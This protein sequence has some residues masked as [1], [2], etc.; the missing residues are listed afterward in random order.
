[1][2]IVLH[3]TRVA[4]LCCNPSFSVQVHKDPVWMVNCFVQPTSR[5]RSVDVPY[6]S[7]SKVSKS[8]ARNS[9]TFQSG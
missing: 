3:S 8:Q 6:I 9:Q 2:Y 7:Y 5:L 1:M 4:G